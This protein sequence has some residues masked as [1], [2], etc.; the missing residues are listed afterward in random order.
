MVK[1]FNFVLTAFDYLII[2]PHNQYLTKKIRIPH[3]IFLRRLCVYV[4]QIKK[5][6]H[7]NDPGGSAFIFFL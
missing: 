3:K 5:H 6:C 2:V 4:T 7:P 1:C